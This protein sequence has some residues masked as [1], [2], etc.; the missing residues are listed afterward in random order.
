VSSPRIFYAYA[1]LLT[2]QGRWEDAL[3]AYLDG[4]RCGVAGTFGKHGSDDSGDGGDGANVDTWREA[5]REVEDVVDVLRNFGPRVQG[6]NWRY[7]ARSVVR[8]FLGRAKD[9]EDESE[10]PCLLKIQ[11]ELRSE[12]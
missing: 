10:W 9:F 6:Y 3:K 7:Q 8:T 11:E 1:R 2:W 4:Y 5:V 12:E